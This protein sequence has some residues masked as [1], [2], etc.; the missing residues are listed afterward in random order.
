[1]DLH[2]NKELFV[3]IIERMVVEKGYQK[4]VI[5]K[6][7]FVTMFLQSLTTKLPNLIFKGGTSLSKCYGIIKRFSEDIDIT[8]NFEGD[9]LADSGRKKIKEVIKMICDEFGFNILNLEDTRSRRNFN[10]YEIEYPTQFANV[11]LKQYLLIESSVAVKSFLSEIKTA[12]SLIQ[13]YLE[14]NDKHDLCKQYGIYEFEIRVQKL[15]RTL[16]DKLFALGD[17]YLT[18]KEDGHSRHIYDIYKLLPLVKI[19]KE[20]RNLVK[21][22]RILRKESQYCYSAQDGKD[23]QKLLQEIVNK[24]T[25][26]KDYEFSTA[27]LLFEKV[28]YKTAKEALIKILELKIF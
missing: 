21:E 27:Y 14:E 12:K 8:V 25:Y 1:M 3:Q 7:Y 20:F 9:H 18:E 28:P 10:Q 19:D 2:K 15:D 23:M 6:D 26:K 5:E 22:V 16:I 24:D 4:E 11:A 13:E 17:Y